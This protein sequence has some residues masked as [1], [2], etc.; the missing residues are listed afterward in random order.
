MAW[1]TSDLRVEQATA[2]PGEVRNVCPHSVLYRRSG[3][4]YVCR[5]CDARMT[6][7]G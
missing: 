7:C 2:A 3:D 6:V 5:K 4:V 1:K